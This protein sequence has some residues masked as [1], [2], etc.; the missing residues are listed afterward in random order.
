MKKV[1]SQKCE[2]HSVFTLIE[3]LV[4]IA[5]IAI[6]AA[7]LLP[8]LNKAREKAKQVQCSNNLKQIGSAHDFYSGDFDGFVIPCQS[9]GAWYYRP[10][11]NI[12]SYVGYKNK[13]IWKAEIPIALCPSDQSPQELTA[14]YPSLSYAQNLQ[15]GWNL[16]LA[17][18]FTKC[19]LNSMFKYP[20]EF[21]M[22]VDSAT[23]Y[24]NCDGSNTVTMEDR[25]N[26]RINLLFRDGHIDS[27][28]FILPPTG[29]LW[30]ISG[31]WSG[32]Y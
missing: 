30:R 28:S 18:K 32:S 13:S 1:V 7:M 26:G 25:H 6:L 8:A 9:T 21:M 31:K 10:E 27:R 5:I 15:S 14:G 20:S 2:N 16:G 23:Y 12:W 29:H 17:N 24:A 4:V 3:L 19:Y 22:T 11:P